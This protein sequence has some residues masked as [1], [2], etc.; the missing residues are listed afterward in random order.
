MSEK[1]SVATVNSTENKETKM[2]VNLS[3]DV[4][5]IRRFD[6]KTLPWTA[7]TLV[8]QMD[9]GTARYDSAV[10]RTLVWTI[11]QK[12]LLIHSLLINAP[13]PPMYCVSY[14]EDGNTYYDFMDGKQRSN[15]IAEF[16]HGNFAL[17]DVPE[18]EMEG[19]TTIDINGLKYDDLSENMKDAIKN[20]GFT[21]YV[22]DDITDDQMG[23]IFFRLNN[24]KSLTAIEKTR[25][26]AKSLE[27]LQQISNHNLFKDVLTDKAMASYTNEDIV[28][29]TLI[30]LKE[31]QPCL[32]TKVVRPFLE[33]VD[34]TEDDVKNLNSIFDRI[35]DIHYSI[36]NDDDLGTNNRKK[37]AKKVV[38]RIHMITIAKFITDHKEVKNLTIRNFLE[39]FFGETKRCS[40]SNVYNANC[41]A[42]SGHTRACELRTKSMNEEFEKFMNRGKK[43]ADDADEVATEEAATPAA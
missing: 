28:V 23:D 25:V 15:A 24:G 20:Y 42:G 3:D 34:I 32:D 8:K 31:S 18:L 4:R 16:I 2:M 1:M 9:K 39:Y 37:I 14:K 19:E 10:Q 26:K 38:T 22:Y 35:K 33:N 36:T 11:E 21:I 6:K 12:S 41:I 17:K 30:M 27:T 13:V 29:K 43:V 5:E 40:V 7:S